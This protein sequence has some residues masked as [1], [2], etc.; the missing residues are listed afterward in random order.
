MTSAFRG[1]DAAIIAFLSA[2]SAAAQRQERPALPNLGALFIGDLTTRG[3]ITPT[4]R[5]A[6][7]DLGR[8][9]MTNQPHPNRTTEP[10]TSATP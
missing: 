6:R 10:P 5:H 1:G 2:V 3:L 4:Q 8:P 9:E 7:T